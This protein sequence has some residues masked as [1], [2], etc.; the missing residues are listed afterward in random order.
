MTKTQNQ[1]MNDGTGKRKLLCL[2]VKNSP[3]RGRNRVSNYLGSVH[4]TKFRFQRPSRY[5]KFSSSSAVSC[6]SN[7]RKIFLKLAT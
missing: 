6:R 7:L 4:R 5:F 3:K 2:L 1:G